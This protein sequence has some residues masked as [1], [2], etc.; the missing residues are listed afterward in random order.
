MLDFRIKT[1]LE[2]AQIKNY[3]KTAQKLHLT[4][5]NITQHIQYLEKHY[6]IKLF[7]YENKTLTL[8][9]EGEVFYKHALTLY[10]SSLR[11]KDTLLT[12]TQELIFG[13]TLTIGQYTFDTILSDLLKKEQD[14]R[15]TMYVDNTENLL[16]KLETGHLDFLVIEGH[17]DKSKYASI[18]F[19]YDDFI[20]IS[21]KKHP[22]KD[23]RLKLTDLLNETLILRENGSGTRNIFEHILHQQNLS[24]NSF[25]KIHEVANM[26]VIKTLVR[27]NIGISFLYKESIKHDHDLHIL[28][29]EDFKIK[30]EFNF[31]Y[32]KGSIFEEKYLEYFD[33]FLSVV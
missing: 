20:A 10:N 28:D 5:P 27:E 15:C 33:F 9:K 23:Q 29:I 26:E 11:L 22:L 8:T 12:H 24:T 17:F 7:H 3:T 21:S 14:L 25:H 16:R 32:L 2:L 4:Q 18:H 1:F 6:Q 13:T 30:R 19:K 31:V